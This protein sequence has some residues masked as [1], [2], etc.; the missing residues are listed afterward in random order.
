MPSP[1]STFKEFSE[2]KGPIYTF[3]NNPTMIGIL[4]LIS[5][6]ISLYFIY[7][8]FTMQD[9]SKSKNPAI[10]SILVLASVGSMIS[11]W[12]QT[13][14][15]STTADRRVRSEMQANWQ[16]LAMLGLL[17]TGTTI[18]RRRSRKRKSN[19]RR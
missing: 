6:A 18:G 13:A 17:G 9:G 11:S 7:A 8:S 4:L 12:V 15:D 5:V 3:A 1:F 14:K 16:P 19:P 2:T 10:L